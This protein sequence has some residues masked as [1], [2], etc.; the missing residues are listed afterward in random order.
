MFRNTYPIFEKKRLLKIQMLENLRDFPREMFQILYQD[1]CNGIIK[2]TDFEVIDDYLIIKPGILYWNGVPYVMK[3]ELKLSYEATEKTAYLK[4]KFLEELQSAEKQEYLTQVYMDD[5]PANSL[6]E[7]ELARFKLQTGARLRNEYTDFY[8]YNT[9]F[10]TINRIHAP[11]AASGK[12]TIWP[13]I[14]KTFAKTLMCYPIKNPWDYSFCL[15]CIQSNVGMNKEAITMYLNAHLQKNKDMY[16]NEEIYMAL[17][18][19]LQ[20]GTGIINRNNIEPKME[21]K[22]LLL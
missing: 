5:S 7:I 12:S 16:L 18:T 11:F 20:Q 10:D 3:E 8:D 14:L 13:E 15:N 21:K 2:G 17:K 6:N 4:V 9:E 1:Y 19:I 22:V